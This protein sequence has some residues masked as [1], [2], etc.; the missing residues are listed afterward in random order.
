MNLIINV[1]TAVGQ[2]KLVALKKA[3]APQTILEVIGQRFLAW[4]D[5]SFKTRGRGQWRPLAWGTL[6][7]RPRGGDAPLQDTGR[8]KQSFVLETDNRTRV[9]VGSSIKGPGGVPLSKIHEEGTNPYTIR[10]RTAKVLAARAGQG[11]GGAR[12][13][14]L[15]ATKRVSEWII[16]GKEV[17]HPGI[18]ARPVLPTKQEAEQLVTETVNAMIKRVM[19]T[20]VNGARNG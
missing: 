9:S 20:A 16:F 11:S 8:Y 17:H 19:D 14:G 6:A 13:V 3:V 4:V 7:L 18:P 10:A 1:N 5:E 2:R 12:I 15:I